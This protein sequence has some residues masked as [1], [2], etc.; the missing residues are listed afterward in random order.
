MSTRITIKPHL[1]EYCI[2]KWGSEFQE[3]VEFPAHT[4][5][6]VT[7]YNLTMKR[8]VNCPL[9]SG[10][11]EV[12][13]PN[14]RNDEIMSIRK[15][16]EVYNYISERASKILSRKIELYFWAELHETIDENS[17][18][19][20]ISYSETIY[21]FLAKYKIESITEDALLKNYQRWKEN[22]RK[23]KKRGYKNS[24]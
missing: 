16:P 9:D 20:R 19:Y 15:N 13:L 17:H 12:V 7:I 24:K 22:R 2:G 14:R 4:E 5:L 10:N 18:R 21:T 1:A 3:P 11:L 23:R 8:P 6:Y